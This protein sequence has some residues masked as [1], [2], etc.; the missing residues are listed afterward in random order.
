M[1]I[2]YQTIFRVEIHPEADARRAHLGF[3]TDSVQT[4]PQ[5]APPK[6]VPAKAPAAKA[7]RTSTAKAK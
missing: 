2:P 4:T 6:P 3:V 7:R 1:F 5:I